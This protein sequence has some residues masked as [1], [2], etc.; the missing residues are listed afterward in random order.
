MDDETRSWYYSVPLTALL[1][2]GAVAI[3]LLGFIPEARK[4]QE[5]EDLVKKAQQRLVELNRREYETRRRIAD[6]SA[7]TGAEVE[8]AIREILRMG[9]TQDFLP[10][11]GRRKSSY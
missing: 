7:G 2:C 5:C 3:F 1:F 11:P 6:L 9:E 4:A 10:R 8:E